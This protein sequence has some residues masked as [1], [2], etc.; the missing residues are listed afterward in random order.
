MLLF[1]F[2]VNFL[3]IMLCHIFGI[4]CTERFIKQVAQDF[5]RGWLCLNDIKLE[6]FILFIFQIKQILSICFLLSCRIY[7]FL[8]GNES[9]KHFVMKTINF[10]PN[11]EHSKMPLCDLQGTLGQNLMLH[12]FLQSGFHG[13]T[14]RPPKMCLESTQ[15]T[16]D[17]LCL[18]QLATCS[19][20]MLWS[21]K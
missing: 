4:K 15:S 18:F 20:R 3:N 11:Y 21:H 9:P 1:F 8:A 7:K 12:S 5:F 16:H 19:H 17:A 13:K 6:H 10:Q 2:C 14:Q